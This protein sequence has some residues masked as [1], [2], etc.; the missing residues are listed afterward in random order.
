MGSKMNN[1]LIEYQFTFTTVDLMAINA[2]LQE[3]PMRIASPL[4]VKI[5]DQ[6]LKQQELLASTEV[7][8]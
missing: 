8:P 3:L 5:N 1:D 7:K 4:I 2:A 6:I